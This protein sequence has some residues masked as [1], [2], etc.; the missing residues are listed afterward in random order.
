MSKNT[1]SEADSKNVS[2][3]PTEAKKK[4]QRFHVVRGI[5]YPVV[6]SYYDAKLNTVVDV[7]ELKKTVRSQ[8]GQFSEITVHRRA[9][10]PD[11]NI[12][13][14]FRRPTTNTEVNVDVD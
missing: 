10:C 14:K 5:S 6:R 4:A 3:T 13:A 12:Q 8:N 7:F 9:V 2:P 1:P 11:E